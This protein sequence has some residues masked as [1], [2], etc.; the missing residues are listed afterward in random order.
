MGNYV[1]TIIAS[2]TALT[3]SN[4]VEGKV[5]NYNVKIVSGAN[6][7]GYYGGTSSGSFITNQS[8]VAT[9]SLQEGTYWFC[10]SSLGGGYVYNVVVNNNL[11]VEVRN[12]AFCA[13]GD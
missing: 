6:L 3:T 5:T 12:G 7:Y 10:I 4:P 1:S 2:V 11:T 8:G 9:L 13:C